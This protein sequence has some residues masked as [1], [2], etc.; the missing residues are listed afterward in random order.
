MCQTMLISNNIVR[1]G[2]RS[3]KQRMEVLASKGCRVTQLARLNRD[4]DDFYE[5]LYS[6][7]NSITENDYNFF[8]SQLLVMLETL[9]GLHQ[10]CMSLST[11]LNYQKEVEKLAMNYSAIYEVNSDIVNFKIKVKEDVELKALMKQASDITSRINS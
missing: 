6:Q 5:L 8:G 9:K 7:W 3:Y 4:L 1:L 2:T 10:I 11:D